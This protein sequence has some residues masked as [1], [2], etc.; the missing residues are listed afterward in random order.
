MWYP[1]DEGGW[2]TA[3]LLLGQANPGG[4][5]PFTWPQRLEQN[6]A[7]DPEH[8][9]RSLTGV[10]GTTTYS[11]G[12]YVGYRWFDQQQLEPLFPFGFGLS[13]SK[14]VYSGLSTRRAKDGGA[15]V[16]FAIRNTGKYAG[17]EVP[18]AYLEA[19][20][21][22]VSGVQFAKRSLSAF[23]RVTLKAGETRRVTLHIPLRQLQYW[24]E[25]EQGWQSAG[26]R[27]V[28]IAASSRDVRLR[29]AVA[30]P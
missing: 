1:G 9:E 8:P 12:I 11:E 24:S 6:A 19:P 23:E 22:A 18:Q 26:A 13:Y 14:F 28:V 30:G 17:D 15:D 16:S 2:A 29:G 4:R 10:D 5:L 20:A 7:N 21:T 3:K 27:S 25:A